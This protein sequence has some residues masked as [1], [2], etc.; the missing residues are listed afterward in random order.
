MD[1]YAVVSA[2]TAAASSRRATTCGST[3]ASRS[4]TASTPSLQ[5]EIASED[6]RGLLVETAIAAGTNV[7]AAGEDVREGDALL[8]AGRLL[9]AYDIALAAVA[10]HAELE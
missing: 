10:G 3:R 9:S 8:P 2:A 7:R 4:R 6:A 5:I 1:G